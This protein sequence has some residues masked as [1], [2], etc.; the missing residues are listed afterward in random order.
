MLSTFIGKNLSRRPYFFVRDVAVTK[1]PKK[2]GA[3]WTPVAPAWKKGSCDPF[4][5]NVDE[6]SVSDE[7]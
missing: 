5:G 6:I 3:A 2:L 1:W 7:C 4:F